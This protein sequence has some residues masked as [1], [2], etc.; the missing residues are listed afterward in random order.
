MFTLFSTALFPPIEYFVHIINAEKVLIEQHESYIKQ[1]YRNRF[2]I[3]SPNG[4]LPLTIPITKPNGN[5]TLIKDINI[6]YHTNWQTLHWRSIETAYNSSPFMLY[7]QDEFSSFF[8]S[9]HENLLNFNTS[10]LKVLLDVI[11][12]KKEVVLTEIF[13]SPDDIKTNDEILD[14]RYT[15]TPK[16]KDDESITYPSYTQ[17]FSQKF[18][19]LPDL[20]IIDLLFNE[21]PSTIDYLNNC[22]IVSLG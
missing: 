9:K 11:G 8:C 1:S 22:H 20:S 18:G 10:L 5:K 13:L 2:N 21:G 14:L 17:I 6:S 15:I 12:I 16:Q 19:F 3:Y 7:Y 4:L